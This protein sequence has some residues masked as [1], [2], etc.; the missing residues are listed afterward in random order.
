MSGKRKT[1]RGI[2]GAMVKIHRMT[3]QQLADEYHSL[4]TRLMSVQLSM[5]R[6]ALRGNSIHRRM[7]WIIGELSRRKGRRS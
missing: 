3:P 4:T 1:P 2:A 6:D 5:Y 7:C